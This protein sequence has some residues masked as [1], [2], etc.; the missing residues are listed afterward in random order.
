[1]RNQ[2]KILSEKYDNVL[3]ESVEEVKKPAVAKPAPAKAPAL[4]TTNPFI[5]KVAVDTDRYKGLSKEEAPAVADDSEAKINAFATRLKAPWFKDFL[6]GMKPGMSWKDFE[7]HLYKNLYNYQL[8]QYGDPLK[9]KTVASNIWHRE[10]NQFLTDLAGYYENIFG[11]RPHHNDE[12]M[13]EEGAGVMH[14]KDQQAKAAGK[15][16]FELGGKEFPVK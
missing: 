9:A 12:G 16:T 3:Q 1:M 7:D 6:A 10:D 11:Q 8:K 15:D 13:E 2:Y 4:K 14:F 5:K